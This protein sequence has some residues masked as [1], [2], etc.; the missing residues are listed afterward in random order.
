MEIGDIVSFWQGQLRTDSGKWL[1][2]DDMTVFEEQVHRFN[3]D[4]PVSPYVGDIENAPVI[5]LGANAGY[6]GDRTPKEFPDQAAIDRYLDRVRNPATADWSEMAKYYHGTN[7][8][9]LLLNG[10]AVWIN[11]CAYRSSKLSQEPENRRLISKLPSA[12]FTRRWLLEAVMPLAERGERL[13]VAKR[14]G[15]WKLPPELKGAPGIVFDPAPVSPQI[16]SKPWAVIQDF[17][18]RN[19]SL[20]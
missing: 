7:Y 14:F 2:R 12:H 5:I 11:A 18:T 4:Y 19:R 10:N 8:G 13:V 20:Q 6:K 1:H 17:I 3:L 9:L 15:Q 16:T